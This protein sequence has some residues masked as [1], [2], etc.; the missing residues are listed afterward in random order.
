MRVQDFTEHYK[1][2]DVA[3]VNRCA[4]ICEAFRA[5]NIKKAKRLEINLFG[6]CDVINKFEKSIE[7]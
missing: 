3:M 7:K 4:A 6:K 5:G 1:R 2:L